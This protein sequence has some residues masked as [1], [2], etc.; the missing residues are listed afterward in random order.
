MVNFDVEVSIDCGT[1]YFQFNPPSDTW[2]YRMTSP[3][4]SMTYSS[5]VDQYIP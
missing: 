4:T 3:V 2:T 1:D 5:P